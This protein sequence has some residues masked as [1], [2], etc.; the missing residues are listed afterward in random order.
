MGNR[1]GIKFGEGVSTLAAAAGRVVERSLLFGCLS[2]VVCCFRYLDK[3]VVILD[4]R[5]IGEKQIQK[6]RSL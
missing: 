2:D 5:R 1:E 3:V 6:G 4:A